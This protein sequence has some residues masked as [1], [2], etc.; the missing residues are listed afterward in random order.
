MFAHRFQLME[1]NPV[2]GSN[3][4]T[5]EPRAWIIDV[6]EAESAD[7]GLG[8]GDSVGHYYITTLLNRGKGFL[9]MMLPY[10]DRIAQRWR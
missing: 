6:V 3:V 5:T 2:V 8:G 9:A 1:D 10:P 7:S 4:K